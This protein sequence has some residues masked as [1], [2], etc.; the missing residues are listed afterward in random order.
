[1]MD[2]LMKA[3]FS[4]LVKFVKPSSDK[5]D[6]ESCKGQL[7]ESNCEQPLSGNDAVLFYKDIISSHSGKSKDRNSSG[8]SDDTSLEQVNPK[9]HKRGQLE[10]CKQPSN[11]LVQCQN[12]NVGTFLTSSQNG[13]LA[14]VEACLTAGVD[15]NSQ[16]R[17]GWTAL[18]CAACSG[19][20]R[21]VKQLLG[22]GANTHLTA[23]GGKTAASIASDAGHCG[24]MKLIS[25]FDLSKR[26]VIDGRTRSSS[27]GTNDLEVHTFYC[28]VC[29]Q[30][31]KEASQTHHQT[32]TVH[33]FNKKVKAKPHSFLEHSRNKGYQIM[34]RTGWDGEK[35]L[36]SEGQGQKFPVKTV[37]KKDRACL[38]SDRSKEKAKVT[39]FGPRDISAV[40]RNVHVT[41]RKMSARTL[42]KRAQ[43]AKERKLNQWEKKLRFE[44][45]LN[46]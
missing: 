4:N 5:A 6:S 38:G 39:H 11:M 36:G 32:S 24:I 20:R 2:D 9:R 28:D 1:M 27:T 46:D 12:L 34:R 40:K 16:D 35:G 7:L 21:V 8:Q 13:D 17:F 31:I 43:K 18:M 14:R 25:D 15:V 26:E 10:L 37:I 19:Q 23:S 3:E 44:F 22:S 30:D 45:N 29:K 41:E 42:S 33:L